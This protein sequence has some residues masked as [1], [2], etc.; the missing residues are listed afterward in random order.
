MYSVSIDFARCMSGNGFVLISE[1]FWALILIFSA[2]KENS[3]IKL[4]DLTLQ[5]NLMPILWIVFLYP[6]ISNLFYKQKVWYY[7]KRQFDSDQFLQMSLE[8]VLGPLGYTGCQI[9]LNYGV[10]I[11]KLKLLDSIQQIILH[12]LNFLQ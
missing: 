11:V 9:L 4:H 2:W 8:S 1:L 5:E 12:F 6:V 7:W 10:K 3:S